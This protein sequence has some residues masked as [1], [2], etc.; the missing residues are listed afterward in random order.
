MSDPYGI[1]FTCTPGRGRL[2]RGWAHV[3]VRMRD[4][5]SLNESCRR[6]KHSTVRRDNYKSVINNRHITVNWL[7]AA[8]AGFHLARFHS[9]CVSCFVLDELTLFYNRQSL[10]EREKESVCNRCSTITAINVWQRD[11]DSARWNI[12]AFC[13]IFFNFKKNFLPL[14][15]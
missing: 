9:M 12:K 11:P 15:K 13:A 1:G 14:T 4:A 5:A 3:V 10:R 7:V 6:A 8:L 2:E